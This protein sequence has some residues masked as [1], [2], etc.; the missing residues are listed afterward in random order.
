MTIKSKLTGS[1][2]SAQQAIN[3]AGTVITTE[4]GAGTTAPGAT[5]L[6]LDD[7]H[8]IS[9]G[10][11]NSG[12]ILPPGNGTGT[13]M[14]AGDQMSVI[15]YTGNSLIVYPPLGGKANNGSANA[16]ITISNGKSCD[17]YCIDNINFA[18]SSSA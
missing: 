6:S 16:G 8:V 14:S 13:G 7:Y 9:T 18:V 15:N 2:F 11:N 1:G 12:V 3:A 4:A 10:S 17:C 5:L